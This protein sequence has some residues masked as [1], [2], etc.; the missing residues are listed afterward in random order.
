MI[1]YFGSLLRQPS[2]IFRN[3]AAQ[4]KRVANTNTLLSMWPVLQKTKGNPRGSR[5]LGDGYVLLGPKETDLYHVSPDER[6]AIEDF[7]S[8][9]PGAE[10]INMYAIYRWGR[11][12]LPNEQIARSWMKETER[13]TDMARI[14]RNIK[15]CCG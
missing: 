5:D 9:Y 11:L 14:D 10:D 13:C 7:F 12:K 4:T 8:G 1:G 3:L 6:R 2:N 15:V